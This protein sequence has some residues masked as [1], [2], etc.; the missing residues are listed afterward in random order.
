MS[1]TGGSGFSRE[2]RLLA[3][4]IGV[5]IVVLLVLSRFRFPDPSVDVRDGTAAQPLAR[6]AARAAFDDL[7]LAVRDLSTRVSGSLLVVRTSDPAAPGEP[8]APGSTDDAHLLPALRVRDD[9][10]V[11]LTS[12]TRVV[13]SVVGIPGAVTIVARDPVRGITLVRVPAAPAPTLPVRDGQQPIATPG[14]LAVTEASRTGASV[15]PFFVGRSDVVGDPRWDSPLITVGQGAASGIG[16][17]VFTLDGR[18]AGVI[19]SSEGSPAL[20]PANVLLAA[21]DQLLA[22]GTPPIG[23]I[24]IVAQALDP[25]LR[26]ATGVNA[27]A[28]IAAVVSDGPAAQAFVAG[29]VITA[30]NGQPVRSPDALRQRVSRAAPGTTLSLTVRRDGGFFTAPVAV[31]ARP[32]P[33]AP[34]PSERATPAR[35]AR[36]L[37]LSMRELPGRGSEITRVQSGS[38]ADAAG[39]EVGDIV[40]SLGRVRAPAPAAVTAAFADLAAGSALLVGTERD[41]RPRLVAL[42]R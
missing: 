15:R 25:Q 32:A 38:A 8:V 12:G 37:G 14:Y 26:A 9:T 16:A 6:L 24:G 36:A 39:L 35:A 30:V 7:S 3:A 10:A 41:S 2:T 29:D 28:A 22:S 18:L 20:V 5:S 11:V 34:P 19:Q 21:V 27:G 13:D 42:T 23:D 33:A 1:T 40:V 31:R 17:P 4:T